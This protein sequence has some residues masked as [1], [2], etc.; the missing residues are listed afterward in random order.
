MLWGYQFSLLAAAIKDHTKN[1]KKT[2]LLSHIKYHTVHNKAALLVNFRIQKVLGCS[3]YCHKH[4]KENKKKFRCK[5]K[6]PTEDR[7]IINH[8]S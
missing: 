5:S 8:Q 3:H 4:K 2:T 1:P 6:K 7:S